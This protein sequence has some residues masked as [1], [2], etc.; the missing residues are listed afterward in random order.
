M[1]AAKELG[2]GTRARHEAGNESQPLGWSGFSVPTLH[3]DSLIHAFPL[4][5]MRELYKYSFTLASLGLATVAPGMGATFSILLAKQLRLRVA[6]TG[7]SCL[8]PHIGGVHSLAM[9][10][11]L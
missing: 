7:K 2:G 6:M 8:L 1:L 9:L 5:E 10:F 11:T 3:I 4:Q